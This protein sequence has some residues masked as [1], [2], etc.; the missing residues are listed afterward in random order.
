M[1]HGKIRIGLMAA[2]LTIFSVSVYSAEL[3]AQ[4]DW[5]KQWDNTVEL[6]R[7]E[8]EIQLYGPHDPAYLPVWAKFQSVILK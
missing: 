6:A 1:F 2:G 4:S 5:K 7:R 8:G 3:R